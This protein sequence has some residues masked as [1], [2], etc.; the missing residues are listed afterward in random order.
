MAKVAWRSFCLAACIAAVAACSSATGIKGSD[1]APSAGELRDSAHTKSFYLSVIG[2]LIG[3]GQAYAAMAH[4]DAFDGK[5]GASALSQKLRGDAWLAVGDLTKAEQSYDAITGAALSG[6]RL[7]GLGRV[8]AATGD[9]PR[10]AD[11]FADAVAAAP[12]NPEFLNNLGSSLIHTGRF[13]EAEF[14]LRK[15]RQLAPAD[16]RIASNLLL[17][18]AKTGKT[19]RLK[20]IFSDVNDPAEMKRLRTRLE[21]FAEM[22]GDAADADRSLAVSV[23]S[24]VQ[25]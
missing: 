7:N 13:E 17:L 8:A 5:F 15:A 3:N 12:A 25:R 2:Q 4:L 21:T 1:D 11:Y 22:Q 6:F 23:A 20:E 14:A 18:L 24:P 10:S 9:W 16:D 19:D